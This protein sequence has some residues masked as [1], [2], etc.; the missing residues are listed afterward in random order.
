EY[1]LEN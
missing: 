1:I